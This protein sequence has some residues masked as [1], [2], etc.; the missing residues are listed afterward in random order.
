MHIAFNISIICQRMIREKVN[1][2]L[3][4]MKNEQIMQNNTEHISDT[5]H[6]L[7]FAVWVFTNANQPEPLQLPSVQFNF[8]KRDFGGRPPYQCYF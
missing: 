5:S 6:L 7:I 3:L 1:E 8:L 4:T 2:C